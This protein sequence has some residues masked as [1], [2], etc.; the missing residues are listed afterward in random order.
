M[1]K[2]AKIRK[3]ERVIIL[4][5]TLLTVLFALLLLPTAV[6]AENWQPIPGEG[7]EHIYYDFDSVE[8]SGSSP[9]M[10][11]VTV[12]RDLSVDEAN[13]YAVNGQKPDAIVVSMYINTIER[14]FEPLAIVL[15]QDNPDKTVIAIIEAQEV[16]NNVQMS[17]VEPDVKIVLIEGNEAWNIEEMLEDIF[18]RFK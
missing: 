17:V 5:K 13:D 4:K 3:K 1:L 8:K 12:K 18:L 2:L 6:F 9:H 11:K 14:Y 16:F 10:L 15:V 7:A